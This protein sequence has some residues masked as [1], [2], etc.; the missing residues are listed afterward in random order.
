M[1]DALLTLKKSRK[2][3]SDFLYE[4]PWYLIIGPPGAG[5]TTAL[6]NSGLEFPLAE[7]FGRE[8]LKG[9]GGTRNCDWWFTDQ[10][11]LLDTAGRYTTQ[12]SHAEVDRQGWEGFLALLKKHRK[13]RPINGLLIAISLQDLML[14]DSAQIIDHANAVRQRVQELYDYFG[15]RF[16]IYVLLTKVDL[17]AGFME[18]FS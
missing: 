5:K 10:A 3:R 9:V 11:V 15:V 2:T 1:G 14:L 8:G 4:L 6:L 16:P 12:D 7:R 13:R 17:V 18:F